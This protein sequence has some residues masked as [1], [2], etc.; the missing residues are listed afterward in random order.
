MS[1]E[2]QDGKF[3]SNIFVEGIVA[4]LPKVVVPGVVSFVQHVRGKSKVMQV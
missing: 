4:K 2:P 3:T 1:L